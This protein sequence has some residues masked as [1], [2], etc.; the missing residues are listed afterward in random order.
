MKLFHNI[1]R[2]FGHS[3]I[4]RKVKNLSRNK[5]IHNFTTAG[6]AGLIFNCHNEDE[7]KVVNE[8][9]QF[10]E[11]ESIITDV[12]G[13]VSEKQVP[14]HY[15]LRKGYNFF[16]QKDLTWYYIP[17]VA[18]TNEFIKKNYD[19]LFDLS[20]RELL[21]LNY[22]VSLSPAAYKI[23]RYREV[24]QYDLMIDIKDNKSVSYLIDQIKHYLS[25]LHTKS[26]A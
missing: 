20:L 26:Q 15:L 24:N 1:R 14:D 8:F 11:S 12:I 4:D 7:F 2:Y 16:C 17:N 18:F 5:R 9:R 22:I 19:I 6:T 3:N 25:I 10:L 13:Y 23:G 21:P